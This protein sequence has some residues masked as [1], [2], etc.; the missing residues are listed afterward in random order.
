[1][2]IEIGCGISLT[3][4]ERSRRNCEQ[5]RVRKGQTHRSLPALVIVEGTT[6]GRQGGRRSLGAEKAC[7]CICEG[8]TNA[9]LVEGRTWHP[10]RNL[11]HVGYHRVPPR[12]RLVLRMSWDPGVRLRDSNPALQKK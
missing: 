11:N 8:P 10:P 3:P 12:Q 7:P 2:D 1:M 4:C 9:L 5:A 6:R